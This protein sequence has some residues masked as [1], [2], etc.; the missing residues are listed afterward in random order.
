MAWMGWTLSFLSDCCSFLSSPVDRA[1]ARF[2]FLRGVPL[3]LCVTKSRQNLG[4]WP[5]A[6]Q[7]I[8]LGGAGVRHTLPARW[9][10][11][12]IGSGAARCEGQQRTDTS[13]STQLLEP[14]LNVRHVGLC[15]DG[16]VVG[17]VEVWPGRLG[18]ARAWIR[19]ALGQ[20][21]AERCTKQVPCSRRSAAILAGAKWRQKTYSINR[22]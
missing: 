14:F 12:P 13:R 10:S 9:V 16:V 17:E 3:P 18:E 5:C 6:F 19:S 7:A 15:V 1:G 2:T 21:R 22:V 4:L 20:L 8:D 11:R